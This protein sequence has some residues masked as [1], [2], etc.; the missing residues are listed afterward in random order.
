M[1]VREAS[2]EQTEAGLAPAADGW[3]VL[4]AREAC[5]LQGE[6]VSASCELAGA[7]E[8]PQVGV[9]LRVL[10]PG[11]PIAMY[12]WEADQEDFLV[13]SGAALLIV[14]GEERPLRQWDFVHCPPGT[15]HIIIGAGDVPC[16]VVAVG[17]ASIRALRTGADMRSTKPRSGTGQVWKRRRPMQ[18][19]RTLGFR[20]ASRGRIGR[21]GFRHSS[22]NSAQAGGKIVGVRTVLLLGADSAPAASEG[23]TMQD[24]RDRA[25]LVEASEIGAGE[26][27][28]TVPRAEIQEV[29]SSKDGEPE[30]VIDVTRGGEAEAHTL[31]LAWDPGD[32]EEL[33]RKADGDNV[34]LTFN[35]SEL[36]QALE[37]DVA[38][39]GLREAAVVLAIAASTAA[40]G[41]G[42][43]QASAGPAPQAAGGSSV[44]ATTPATAPATAGGA[45]SEREW[46]QTV[47]SS[48]T[49]GVSEREW[50]QV[51]QSAPTSGVS[52]REWPQV[53]SETPGQSPAPA[54]AS[55]SGTSTGSD[56]A[57]AGAVAGGAALMIGAAAF[58]VRRRGGGESQPA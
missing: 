8:F 49:S 2:L 43:A 28:A 20:N 38:A 25:R 44:A 55:D 53:V 3:F 15:K 56:A 36:E 32:L 6:G 47:Q 42:V 5:W 18:R 19:A 9:F 26:I 14:E 57:I 58:T 39:H 45:V 22:L 24:V 23:R 51:V 27:Q 29:L 1:V 40:T 12:H 30:L 46:P 11:E 50:P 31:R 10:G 17:A 52:E 7:K 33:L 21:A 16:A 37:D 41:V 54:A 34:T 13:L 48:P 4:N 35:R